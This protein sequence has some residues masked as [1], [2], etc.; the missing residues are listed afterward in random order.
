MKL[1]DLLQKFG[2]VA[3]EEATQVDLKETEELNELL[4]AFEEKETAL[5][6]A[7]TKIEALEAELAQFAEAKAAA[8]KSAADAIA[9]AH[10]D[11]VDARLSQ[12]SA[13]FGDEKA[14]KLIKIAE[15]MED[16]EYAEV[17]GIQKELAAKEE[18]TFKE[19][20]IEG[21]VKAEKK[22]VHFNTFIKKQKGK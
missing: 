14:A 1:A 22:P 17:F 2:L 9:K 4:A 15:N 11:K 18:V 19:Q 3:K 6:S 5:T 10:Q 13:E 21:Q 8:E 20:G 7:T 16:A 12:L